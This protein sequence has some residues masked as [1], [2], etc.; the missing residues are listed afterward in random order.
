MAKQAAALQVRLVRTSGRETGSGFQL[1]DGVTRVGRSAD[2]D[3]IINEP[4]VSARHFEILKD[5]EH[6]TIRDLASTNGTFVDGER[7]RET[8]LRP[9][10][11]VR[12][13]AT[14]PEFSLIAAEPEHLDA[15]MHVRGGE[16]LVSSAVARVRAA[17]RDG[18]G[19]STT[20][21]IV[22]EMIARALGRA[23]RKWKW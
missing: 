4:I 8:E 19:H 17:R 22:R 21:S 18:A 15:T 11:T 16:T 7:I 6:Y 10:A 5:G 14:G 12:I 20:S 23:H 3:L 9:P 1:T 2:N 13:G